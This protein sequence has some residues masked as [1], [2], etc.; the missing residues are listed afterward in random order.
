MLGYIVLGISIKI[1]FC[2]SSLSNFF[3]KLTRE[4]KQIEIGEKFLSFFETRYSV[5][6]TSITFS[7]IFLLLISK[8]IRKSLIFF[9]NKK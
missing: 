1:I 5:V 7:F 3:S 2:S 4:E 8:L 9:Y 6:S